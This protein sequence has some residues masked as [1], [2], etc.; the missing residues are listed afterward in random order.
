[1]PQNSKTVLVTGDVIVDHHIYMGERFVPNASENTGTQEQTTE[2]G[3]GLLHRI[4]EAVGKKRSESKEPQNPFDVQFGLKVDIFE[5]LPSALNGYALWKPFPSEKDQKV[6]RIAQPLGYGNLCGSSFSYA[7]HAVETSNNPTMVV[8]DDGGLG[9]RHNTQKTAW[10]KSIL[11]K[12]SSGPEWVVLK[13]SSPVGQGDLWRH[14]STQF[15]ERLVVVVSIGDIRR[16]E[17]KVSKGISWERTALDLAEE[18]CFNSEINSLLNCR[19]LIIHFGSEGALHV[20]NTTNG[21]A[22]HLVYDPE[23]LEREWGG[24][25][26]GSGL[27]YMACLT[28][29]IVDRLLQPNHPDSI[30]EGIRAG[31]SAM[32]TMHVSGHGA[33]GYDEPG[34]PMADVV[35]DVLN[36]KFGYPMIQMPNP[37]KSNEQERK[38]WTIMTAVLEGVHKNPRPLFGIGR[39]VA[40]LGPKALTQIPGARFGKLYTA[41]RN[42]IE[43]L[44]NI[45]MMI[46]DYEKHDKGKKPLS[47]AVFG[48]PGAGKSFGICEIARGILGKEVPILEFN[49]S[50]FKGPD[51]LIGAFHQVRDKALQGTTPVVF[52]DEF[53]SEEY[54]WLQYLLAPMQDGKFL[55]VHIT[56]PIGKSIFVFAG[57][58]SFDM[59]NFGPKETDEKK[60]NEF[61]LKKGPDFKSRLSGYLNVLGPNRRQKYDP[62]QNKWIDDQEDICYPVRRALLIRAMLGLKDN[63]PLNI[64]HGILSALIETYRFRH[65]ARS[66]EKIIL[67]LKKTDVPSIRRSDLPSEEILSIHADPTDFAAIINRDLKFKIHAEDLAPFVHDFYRQLGK[68]EKWIRPEMDKDFDLLSE[69]YKEDNRAAAVRIPHVLD[70]VG[71]YVVPESFPKS[72]SITEIMEIIEAN[73]EILAE[74]EHNDWME[75][76]IK[77]GWT[78]GEPRDDSKKIHDCMKPYHELCEKN[79]EKDR[80]AVRHYQ[81]IL[82]EAKYKIVAS[83]G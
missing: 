27:G 73:I 44:Q 39:R 10:P 47:I 58:T 74:A 57:G 55:E 23:H 68:K 5:K 66:L 48:P 25:V 83:L 37:E 62:K 31:L 56:H 15:S 63:E 14:L 49:L 11:K 78:Y 34:F 42:E 65:G 77:N 82:K 24:K 19:H 52:W 9:F 72:Q 41:D 75:F 46:E 71:L 33:A 16:E 32:R 30:H 60:W 38:T 54:K 18:L 67:Q 28:S 26:E 64:D 80:N 76:K 29:G 81:D 6:W 20:E 40:V 45:R 4:L 8:I 3:V 17:V 50:Q 70:L 53:D 61:K 69:D 12:Q 43:S 2:G 13:M 1:M 36:P 22:F 79:K 59:E 51:D 7:E 21:K 35:K